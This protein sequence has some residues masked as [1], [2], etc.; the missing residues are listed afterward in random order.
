[1]K[2][3]KEQKMLIGGILLTG[4][5]AYIAYNFL[6]R[7]PTSFKE[8]TEDL[9]QT[10]KDI[11]KIFTGYEPCGFPLRK[12][13]GGEEVMKL[14]EFLNKSGSYGLVVDGKFGNLTENAVIEEQLPWVTFKATY[15]DA[16]KGQVTKEYYD[17]F[18]G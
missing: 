17:K 18:I 13:C 7:R 10:V 8:V 1:M 11:P 16:V 5:I 9:T 4:G 3:T 12:G 2:I 15:P 14:Q 6:K